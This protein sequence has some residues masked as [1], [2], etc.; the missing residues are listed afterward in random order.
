V[1]VAI[2]G[3]GVSGLACALTLEKHG[4]VP[5]VFEQLHRPG[6]VTPSIQTILQVIH[7][8][9]EDPLR[10]LAGRFGITL[11]PINTVR[12]IVMISPNRVAA[13][14]GRLGYIFER[15]HSRTS[16]DCELYGRLSR[17]RVRFNAGVG[18]QELA[19]EYDRVVVA[20]GSPFLAMAA[21]RYHGILRTWARGAVVEGSFDPHALIVWF[22]KSYA[23]NGFAYLAPFSARKASLILEASDLREEEVEPAWRRFLETEKLAYREEETFLREHNVGICCPRQTGNLLFVGL[24]AGLLDYTLGFGLYNAV[25]SGVV[26]ARCIAGGSSY[27]AGIRD[28]LAKSYYTYL[29]RLALNRMDNDDLDKMLE[30]VGQPWVNR[31]VYNT[32]LDVVNLLGAVLEHGQPGPL[33]EQFRSPAT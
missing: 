11:T 5:D 15:G 21:G 31:L 29:A 8:P 6:G 26:A 19:G 14:R 24:A 30:V 23:N 1:K 3:A 13:A 17:A 12:K 33:R 22:D 27:E 18:Y 20:T 7:R 16:L 4:I 9:A 28:M 32:G 2:I 10:D 25:V